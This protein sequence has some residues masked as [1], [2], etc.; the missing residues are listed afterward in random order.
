MKQK[1]L[2]LLALLANL[3]AQSQTSSNFYGL[4]RKNT[5]IDAVYLA[6][7]N[8]ATGVVTN[9][10]DTSLSPMVNLTGAALDP[11][12]NLYHFMGYNEIKSIDL[13]SGNVIRNVAI[14]NPLGDS[15]FDNFR[16]NNSD[17]TL[18]GLAR[19]NTYDSITMTNFGELYLATINTVSGE[20][21]QISDTSVGQGYALSGSAIDPYQMVYYY[22]TGSNFIGLDMY[23][24]HIYSNVTM[25]LGFGRMFDNFTYSCADTAIYGLI[26]QNYYDTAYDPFDSSFYWLEVDST[27]IFLGKINPNTGIVTTISPTSLA[28]GGYTLN[29][30]AT[31]DPGAMVYYYN[32]GAELVGVSLITGLITS[33]PI[34]TNTNGQFFELMRI[35]ANCMEATR[36]MRTVKTTATSELQVINDGI[37]IFPN[38]TSDNFSINSPVPIS[39][40]ELF[41]SIGTLVSTNTGYRG[42]INT[43]ELAA[44]M[45]VVKIWTDA[46]I[47][48]Q[49]LWKQ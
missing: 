3:G 41:S 47:H 33:H 2:F 10:S 38:P 37:A 46:G 7:V 5:P 32:N 45:Y 31:I 9:I 15:Y 13:S 21:T 42:P 1:F 25:T 48:V 18:Y 23:T 44:G 40:V 39:K 6:T 34:L 30:G 49:K 20:I 28:S 43:S 16:F 24:G 14:T 36:P 22:S 11:Y 29:A 8:P 26:R 19:R 27:A 12:R 4:A 17:S 35:S